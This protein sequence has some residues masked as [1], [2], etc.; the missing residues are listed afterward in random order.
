[1]EK[2]NYKD[3]MVWQQAIALVPTVYA[4]VRCLPREENYALGDQLR[5]AA[6]SV[7]ANI[8]EGQ[9]RRHPREFLQHLSIAKGSLAELHT[10]LIICERLQYVSAASLFELET[11]IADLSRPLHR[12]HDAISR[13]PTTNNQP[14]TASGTVKS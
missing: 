3:L 14:R 12:L 8:A 13:L 2:R 10:L 7:P 1:M 9:A 6:V 11:A 4:V 5:R